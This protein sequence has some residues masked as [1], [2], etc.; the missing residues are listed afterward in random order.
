MCSICDP[1]NKYNNCICIE[2]WKNFNNTLDEIKDIS[3]QVLNEKLRISTITLCFNLNSNLNMNKLSLHYLCKNKGKFYN[4]YI[5]NWQT[6]YQYTKVVSVKIFP[7]GKIQVAGCKTLMSC[8]YIIRKC[9]NKLVPFMEELNTYNLNDIKIGM[10]NSDFKLKNQINITKL[11]DLLNENLV[12]L[13]G[14]FQS[15]VYQPIKYPAINT[16]FITNDNILDYNNHV[17]KHGIKKKYKNNLS[18]LFFRSG[19]IIITG[20]NNISDYLYV[21]K[22]LLEL[23]CN[24]FNIF[25]KN[26]REQQHMDQHHNQDLLN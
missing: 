9:I 13:N 14:N 10:I 17:Y 24:N 15:V 6:K 19:S 26:C 12:D 8:A 22:Y 2:S 11:C 7:N 21:Y 20:G 25:I 1:K 5:F 16:K 23:F 18:I 3:S 4:A